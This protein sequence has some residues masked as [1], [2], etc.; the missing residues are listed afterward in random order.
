MKHFKEISYL[1]N[2]DPLRFLVY[3]CLIIFFVVILID[4]IFKKKKKNNTAINKN[5]DML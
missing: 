1:L 4:L 2:D 5:E 3:G